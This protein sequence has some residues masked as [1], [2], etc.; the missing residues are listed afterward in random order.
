MRRRR[1]GLPEK[2]ISMVGGEFG[3]Y[4]EVSTGANQHGL[5]RLEGVVLASSWP[6][7]G[8]PGV[9]GFSWAPDPWFGA[10]GVNT[11]VC[12]IF[13][14]FWGCR[15][16]PPSRGPRDPGF[17]WPPLAS[18]GLSW[19]LLASPGLPWPLL[20]SPGLSGPLLASSGLPWLPLASP[21]PLLAFPGLP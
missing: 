9:P 13:G 3:L 5:R 7:P 19:R 12:S 15:R 14:H 11:Q 4:R 20:A 21:G 8:P 6:P 16:V 17:S 10:T 18:P 2:R 1:P